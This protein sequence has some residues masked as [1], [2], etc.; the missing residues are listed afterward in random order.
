MQ[1]VFGALRAKYELKRLNIFL[2]RLPF[3]AWKGAENEST[4]AMNFRAVL[5]A[6]K[7]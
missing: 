2:G 1:N 5:S 4:F 6:T 3:S 7:N